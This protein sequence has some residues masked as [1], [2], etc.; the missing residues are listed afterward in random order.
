[1]VAFPTP[2]SVQ[3]MKRTL[4]DPDRYGERE[5]A[6]GAPVDQK[7]YGWSPP[8]P[9][10]ELFSANRNAIVHDLNVYVP[11]G[12]DCAADDRVIISGETYRCVG[13]NRDYNN[14]P[15]GYTP[16]LVI[17]AKRVEELG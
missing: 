8:G 5:E 3:T 12:F 1:M 14:G 2:F 6:W 10:E 16:G 15:F 7:V 11:S 13:D 4:G 17:R 9:E